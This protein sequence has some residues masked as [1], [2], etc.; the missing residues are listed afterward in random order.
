MK[1][2]QKKDALL[3]V[4]VTQE[5]LKEVQELAALSGKDSV[6]EFVLSTIFDTSPRKAKGDNTD[7]V[8]MV[9]EKHFSD[10]RSFQAQQQITMYIIMQFVMWLTSEGKS[11]E[12]IME[13][14]DAQ[15]KKAAE[16]FENGE[17]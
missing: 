15:Y 8:L 6:S 1:K 12:E 9:L 2:R 5:Q 17:E 11:R 3:N 10:V 7:E 14:Y 13:F 16:R 4:R